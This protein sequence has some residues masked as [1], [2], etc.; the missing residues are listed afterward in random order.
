M[1]SNKINQACVLELEL[2][3]VKRWWRCGANGVGDGLSGMAK[4]YRYRGG[5]WYDAC[6]SRWCGI[7]GDGMGALAGTAAARLACRETSG[8]A[9]Q[10]MKW[11]G[12][13]IITKA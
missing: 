2:R 4:V 6:L 13:I 9:R 11:P 8:S 12:K 1:S 10:E 5:D 7:I 3:P